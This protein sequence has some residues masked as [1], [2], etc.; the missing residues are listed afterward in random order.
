MDTVAAK[1]YHILD[2][3]RIKN[4]FVS[5]CAIK[6]S[7]TLIVCFVKNA[8]PVTLNKA[9]IREAEQMEIEVFKD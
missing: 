7:N 9:S 2:D 1:T 5:A 8:I 3:T 4:P 6:K